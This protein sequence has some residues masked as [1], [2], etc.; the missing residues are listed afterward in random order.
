MGKF[1]KLAALTA[2]MMFATAPV[3]AQLAD[4]RVEE[5]FVMAKEVCPAAMAA[6][7]AGAYITQVFED[8]ELEGSETILLLNF[9]IIYT[10]GLIAGAGGSAE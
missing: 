7:D 5:V 1:A 4:D 8:K 10:E 2:T 9:C 6:D 3:Q